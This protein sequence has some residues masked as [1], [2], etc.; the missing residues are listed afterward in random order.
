MVSSICESEND[1]ERFVEASKAPITTAKN[2]TFF[3]IFNFKFLFYCFFG[4]MTNK[5]LKK[6]Q[7]HEKYLIIMQMK[8]VCF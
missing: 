1:A 4:S 3:I 5:G 2:N 8:F 6:L 7:D